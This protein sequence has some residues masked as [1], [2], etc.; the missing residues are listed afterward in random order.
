MQKFKV[1]DRVVPHSKTVEGWGKLSS[2]GVWEKAKDNEQPF[3][4]ITK[5]DD[6]YDKPDNPCYAAS[7]NL[8]GGDYF[9]E[10]DLTLYVETPKT[11]TPKNTTYV[12]T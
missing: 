10:S 4:Y 12:N 1:G 9:M 7:D 11:E 5:R 3:L 8:E 2:S 6:R